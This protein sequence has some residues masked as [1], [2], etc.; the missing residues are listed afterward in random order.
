MS[1]FKGGLIGGIFIVF[2]EF[3]L[4][5]ISHVCQQITKGSSDTCQLFIVP[6]SFFAKF[7][8]LSE[9]ISY[10]IVISI[11]IIIFFAFGSIILRKR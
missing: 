6:F 2:I 9:R 8:P 7:I 3:F 11:F 1:W 10:L 4:F 5:T